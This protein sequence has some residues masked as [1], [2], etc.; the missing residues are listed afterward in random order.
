MLAL[1]I[2]GPDGTTKSYYRPDRAFVALCR[3]LRYQ[4]GLYFVLGSDHVLVPIGQL[5]LTRARQDGIGTARAVMAE[6]ARGMHPK[7]QPIAVRRHARYR[8]LV[9]DGNSTTIVARC[10]GWVDLPCI[11]EDPPPGRG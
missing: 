3:E 7:R 10:A 5:L 2:A 9:L 11:L 8:Y 6:A 4:H 1:P